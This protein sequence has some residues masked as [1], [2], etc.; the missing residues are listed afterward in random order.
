MITYNAKLPL[1]LALLSLL[2]TY[3]ACFTMP[4]FCVF[5]FN[6]FPDLHSPTGIHFWTG[7]SPCAAF[8]LLF[9]FISYKHTSH[10]LEERK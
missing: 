4:F 6:K 3:C 7:L 10:Q 2:S 8:V 1:L 9:L 5:K